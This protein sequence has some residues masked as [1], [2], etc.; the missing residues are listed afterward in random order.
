MLEVVVVRGTEDPPLFKRIL[1]VLG[2]EGRMATAYLVPQ[3]EIVGAHTW[4]PGSKMEHI[5][6]VRRGALLFSPTTANRPARIQSGRIIRRY[7]I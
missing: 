2:N 4:H 7:G 1:K 3:V 6:V 5:G